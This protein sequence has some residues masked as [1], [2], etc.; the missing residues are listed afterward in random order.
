MAET[1]ERVYRT[2]SSGT[3]Y[4]PEALSLGPSQVTCQQ[5]P[6]AKQVKTSARPPSTVQ[7]THQTPTMLR[8]L[9]TGPTMAPPKVMCPTEEQGKSHLHQGHRRPRQS[10]TASHDHSF[11]H[12]ANMYCRLATGPRRTQRSEV[13]QVLALVEETQVTGEG[14][15]TQEV[16]ELT[17]ACCPA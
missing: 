9:S 8:S 16:G 2:H 10:S 4:L 12:L 1:G 3:L 13:Y 14:G 15:D 17:G 11:I 5:Q 7:P 6:R